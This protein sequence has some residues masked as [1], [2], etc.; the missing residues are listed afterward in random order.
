MSLLSELISLLLFGTE[1]CSFLF[2][3]SSCSRVLTLSTS[4]RSA[5]PL[6]SEL[7]GRLSLCVFCQGIKTNQLI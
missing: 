6:L 4:C 5:M 2:F 7:I 1:S 3:V